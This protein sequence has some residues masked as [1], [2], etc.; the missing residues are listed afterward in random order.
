MEDANL[1]LSQSETATTWVDNRTGQM[2]QKR[3]ATVAYHNKEV[4]KLQVLAFVE[5]AALVTTEVAK[6]AKLEAAARKTA[7]TDINGRQRKREQDTTALLEANAAKRATKKKG[8]TAEARAESALKSD[9]PRRSIGKIDLRSPPCKEVL[10]GECELREL[11]VKRKRMRDGAD[12]EPT[13][14]V[15]ELVHRL[16]AHE[17]GSEIIE[18]L[19]PYAHGMRRETWDDSTAG[20]PPWESPISGVSL[21][22]T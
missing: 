4:L 22:L 18:K 6:A 12:G 21:S 11:P 2:R 17:G 16:Q 8:W 20:H 19:T 9:P 10:A 3:S 15:K 1:L 7:G 13:E 5:R 14:S